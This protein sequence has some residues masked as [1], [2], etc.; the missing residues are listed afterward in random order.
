M[1]VLVTTWGSRG[2]FQPYLALARGF[3]RAGHDVRL[4]APDIPY[5]H[6]AAAEQGVDYV[7]AGGAADPNEVARFLDSILRGLDPVQQ[8]RRI[9]EGH[10]APSLETAYRATLEHARWADVVVS[11]FFQPAGRMVAEAS[12]RPWVSGSLQPMLPTAQEPPPLVPNL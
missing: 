9:I 10:L 11:H 1:R 3:R 2:D 8:G 4:A 7:A 6:D 12:G 5:F